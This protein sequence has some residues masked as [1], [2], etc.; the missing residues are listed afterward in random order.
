MRRGGVGKKTPKKKIIPHFHD[1]TLSDFHRLPVLGQVI[2][3]TH[4]LNLTHF[5]QLK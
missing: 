2:T 4:T 3:P 1:V 5:T